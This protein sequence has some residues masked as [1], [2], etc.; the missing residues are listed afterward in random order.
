MERFHGLEPL[1]GV[2]LTGAR[3]HRSHRVGCGG[4]QLL[5]RPAEREDGRSLVDARA[6][7]VLFGSHEASGAERPAHL[8][9]ERGV[10]IVVEID[11]VQATPRKIV[12]QA[13]VV[14][15]ARDPAVSSQMDVE[16]KDDGQGVQISR[17]GRLRNR[18]KAEAGSERRA[19]LVAS[20]SPSTHS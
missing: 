11:D 13:A 8:V 12:D 7:L 3:C 6:E 16:C 2:G 17:A 4:K 1:L 18:A 14:E 15:I 19:A 10:A 5:D 20:S 9:I